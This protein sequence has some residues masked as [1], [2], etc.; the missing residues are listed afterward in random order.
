ME[1]IKF[2]AFFL[3]VGLLISSCSDGD[4]DAPIITVTSPNDGDQFKVTDV[5]ELRSTV[6]D[7][8]KL[9][10][11]NLSSDLGINTNVTTF[12]SETSHSYNINL[13][14]DLSTPAGTYELIITATDD[15]DNSA[16][17]IIEVEVIE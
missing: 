17:K 16:E 11:I 15:S 14:F 13:T 9:A 6:T 5:L 12:D 1:K 8:T 10:L 2:I 4:K 7:D 3:L